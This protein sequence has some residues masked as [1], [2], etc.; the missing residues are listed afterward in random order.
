MR[1]AGVFCHGVMAGFLIERKKG[2]RYRYV[3]DPEYT[4]L[5]ISASLPKGVGEF[6]FD[7]FPSFF[8]GLLPEGIMLKSLLKVAKLDGDDLFGQLMATGL[9]LVGAVTLEELDALPD[10]V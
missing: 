3:Y 2:V 4:G 9:D 8:D 5:E 7:S 6:E 10:N 1:V